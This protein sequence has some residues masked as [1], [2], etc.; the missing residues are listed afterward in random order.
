M[1]YNVHET[2]MYGGAGHEYYQMGVSSYHKYL[3]E[4]AFRK[5]YHLPGQIGVNKRP[6]P[7]VTPPF[8][9]NA[10]IISDTIPERRPPR[11]AADG[12]NWLYTK[13]GE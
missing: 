10:A 7:V 12:V 13:R 9:Y 1:S 3:A 11:D 4:L 8:P 2:A 5:A 6:E